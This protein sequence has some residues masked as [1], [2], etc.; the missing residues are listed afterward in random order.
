MLDEVASGELLD[1]LLVD[2]G[3]ITELEGIQAF[4]Y[5]AS[6]RKAV[7]RQSR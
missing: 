6:I 1:L 4:H 5:R 7:T 3:L 2:R